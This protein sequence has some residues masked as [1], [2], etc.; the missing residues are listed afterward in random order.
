[1][2][3]GV[4]I[5]AT[6]FGMAFG[7]WIS[8]VIFDV[9]GSYRAAFANGALWNLLQRLYCSGSADTWRATPGARVNARFNPRRSTPP[10]SADHRAGCGCRRHAPSCRDRA[11]RRVR[12]TPAPGARAARPARSR[13]RRPGAGDAAPASSASTMTGASP[14]SGSSS[15]SSDGLP[16]SARPIASICCSP[17]ESW[18]P[19]LRRRSAS[20]GNRSID[21]LA[22]P[23]RAAARCD[24]EVLVDVQRRKDLAL[25]RHIADAQTRALEWSQPLDRLAAERDASGMQRRVADHRR[26]QR[27][28]ADAVAAQHRQA[29]RLPRRRARCLPAPRSRHSRRDTSCS[30]E[31]VSHAGARRDRPRA[32]AHRRRSP[33]ACLRPGRCPAPAR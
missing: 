28:L 16:I 6:L 15:S 26:Q 19:M 20:A 8:G 4:V 12:R 9:T 24:A 13:V 17:P 10:T 32:R 30:V 18:L 1:M 22:R 31:T 29:C 33:P 21:A 11:R 5:M 25:L 27:R 3:F 14:S 2:R 7:G 23:A